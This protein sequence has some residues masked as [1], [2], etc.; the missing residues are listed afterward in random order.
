MKIIQARTD[1]V[2]IEKFQA[3]PDQ[4]WTIL[5]ANRSGIDD[6]FNL[7][8]GK[9]ID[10]TA[11]VKILPDH[12]GVVSFKDQQAVY[13]SELKKDQTDVMDRPDPGTPARDFLKN[14]DAHAGLIQAL[15]MTDSLDKG[16]RQ[17]ST[18]QSRKLLLLA[19]ITKAATCLVIQSPFDGLDPESCKELDNAMFQLFSKGIQTLIFVCNPADMPS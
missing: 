12:L 2:Y 4:A 3:L 15:G 17:L 8:S 10:G 18:G 19:A 11:A 6:F 9:S 7:V 13:E 1:H 14:I 5:G 16:Y